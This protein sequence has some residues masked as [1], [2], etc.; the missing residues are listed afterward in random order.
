M[1][2]GDVPVI[3]YCAKSDLD[4]E[5]QSAI[6]ADQ[7]KLIERILEL[8]SKV[9]LVTNDDILTGKFKRV[10]EAN[11]DMNTPEEFT[12]FAFNMFAQML[13][14]KISCLLGYNPDEPKNIEKDI[15]TR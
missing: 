3:I 7:I 15:I 8:K 11:I 4:P 1:V 5:L 2:N 6:R 12:V 10:K 14:C 9:Y 13:A